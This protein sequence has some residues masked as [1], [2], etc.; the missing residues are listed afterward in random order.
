MLAKVNPKTIPGALRIMILRRPITSIHFRATSVKMKLVP[1]TIRP[2]A[3]G[4]L[5]PIS[6][7]RV[8]E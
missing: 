2:T 7:K 8:A 1:E 6:L 4:W 3:V 5:N